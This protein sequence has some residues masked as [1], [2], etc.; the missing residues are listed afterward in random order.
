MPT[1]Q[2][3][4]L[5]VLTEEDGEAAHS[6]KVGQ[7]EGLDNTPSELKNEASQQQQSWQRSA[8]RPG[9][10]RTGRRSGHDH[11][12]TS[13]RLILMALRHHHSTPLPIKLHW[14]PISERVKY[15]VVCMCFH[16]INGSCP[17][18]LS[19]LLHIYTPSRTLRSSPDSRI[20][21]IQQYKRKTRGLR[22]FTYFGPYVWNSLPQDIRQCSTLTS[23][24]T[25]LKTF[26]FSQY[27][28]SS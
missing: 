6:L 18:Y 3:E 25:N 7:F 12:H 27:F 11:L 26:L 15:K 16:A 19:E 13:A 2:A 28:H 1:R 20:L 14:L 21:K 17:T 4:S 22:T 10:Q 9:R 8:S 24:T 5:P 23:F